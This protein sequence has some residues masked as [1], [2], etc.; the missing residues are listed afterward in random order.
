[1]VIEADQ[2]L[3]M[4][5]TLVEDRKKAIVAQRKIETAERRADMA[6]TKYVAAAARIAY[7]ESLLQQHEVNFEE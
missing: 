5:Y 7:L 2:V 6:E 3:S 1:M 4:V